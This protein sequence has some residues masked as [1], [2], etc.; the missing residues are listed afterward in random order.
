MAGYVALEKEHLLPLHPDALRRC[1]GD[2][3]APGESEYE[4][5]LRDL[6]CVGHFVDCV[7]WGRARD[8]APGAED[9]E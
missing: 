2:V 1:N 5:G 4:A 6:E 7:G 8:D 9:A 3:N